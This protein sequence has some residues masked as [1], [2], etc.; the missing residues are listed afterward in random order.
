MFDVLTAL[1]KLRTVCTGRPGNCDK[2]KSVLPQYYRRLLD[3]VKYPH[4]HMPEVDTESS[5]LAL[6]LNLM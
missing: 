3:A 4:D 2:D 5:A 1:Q 6:E